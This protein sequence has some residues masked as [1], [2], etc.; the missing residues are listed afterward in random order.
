MK[1]EIIQ[2]RQ[3]VNGKLDNLAT[4]VQS[5]T[6]RVDETESRVEQVEGWTEEV[7][8]TLCTYLK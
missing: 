7:M 4:A 2:L 8:E 5:L 3:E 6:D 1:H